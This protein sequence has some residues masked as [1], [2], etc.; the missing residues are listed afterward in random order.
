MILRSA[1]QM[2]SNLFQKVQDRYIQQ[3]ELGWRGK[4]HRQH[5]STAA[6]HFLQSLT[7]LTSRLERYQRID[8]AV[9]TSFN[10]MKLVIS[11]CDLL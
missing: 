4:G 3:R 10:P 9:T 5:P 7:E 8:H 1:F 6:S 2:V 11:T